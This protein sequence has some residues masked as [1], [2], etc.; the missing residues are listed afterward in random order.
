MIILTIICVVLLVCLIRTWIEKEHW[1]NKYI[2]DRA[3]GDVRVWMYGVDGKW[4][5]V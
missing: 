1:L 5:D 4:H 2:K 3:R